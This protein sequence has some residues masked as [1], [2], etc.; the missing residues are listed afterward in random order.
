[1]KIWEYNRCSTCRKALKYLDGKGISYE[2]LPIRETPPGVDELKA[3]LF[4][5]K[6][7]LKKLFN[8]SGQDYR[9]GNY[10]ELLKTMSEEEAL[11]ALSENGNLI[12]RP[13]VLTEEK[14]IVGFKEEVWDELFG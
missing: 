5:M 6:G 10:K 13:F 11:K 9:A 8:S 1:M 14:G 2:K 3:M 7:D 12:K 4:H